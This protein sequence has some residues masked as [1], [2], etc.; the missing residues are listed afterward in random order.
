[1][2]GIA[3]RRKKGDFFSIVNIYLFYKGDCSTCKMFIYF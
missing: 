1:M 2:S 3:V